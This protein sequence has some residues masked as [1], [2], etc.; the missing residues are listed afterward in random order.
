[1]T[2]ETWKK[3]NESNIKESPEM[4]L[5]KS[6]AKDSQP[7][8]YHSATIE[9]KKSGVGDKELRLEYFDQLKRMAKFTAAKNLSLL[10][11]KY[12]LKNVSRAL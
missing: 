8:Q 9:G 10:G 12:I 3:L 7:L 4:F 1:M 5:H 2:F 11:K 6:T